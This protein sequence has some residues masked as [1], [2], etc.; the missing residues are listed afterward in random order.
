[1]L[2]IMLRLHSL[3][4]FVYRNLF[5]SLSYFYIFLLHSIFFNLCNRPIYLYISLSYVYLSPSFLFSYIFLSF[6][7]CHV[8]FIA[9]PFSF[10][11]P[12]FVLVIFF[13]F[14][15]R[16]ISFCYLI[17]SLLFLLLSTKFRQTGNIS[18]ALCKV[19]TA[20][21]EVSWISLWFI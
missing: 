13:I 21:T 14:L 3:V 17:P 2:S 10:F 16:L 12:T 1:L 15:H 8:S 9:V 7:F 11:F 5:M 20:Q 6:L 4:F 18:F 19:V